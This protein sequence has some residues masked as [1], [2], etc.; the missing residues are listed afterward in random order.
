MD[1]VRRGATLLSSTGLD[2]W[3]PASISFVDARRSKAAAARLP[4]RRK[5]FQSPALHGEYHELVA[6]AGEGEAKPRADTMFETFSL[7]PRKLIS[8]TNSRATF[9]ATCREPANC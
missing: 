5:S 6:W 1:E 9:S 2:L 7:P 3:L 4:W 8:L